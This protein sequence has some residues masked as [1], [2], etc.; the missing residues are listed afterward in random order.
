[1]GASVIN[2]YFRVVMPANRLRVNHYD[3]LAHRVKLHVRRCHFLIH[4]VH[5]MPIRNY[6]GIK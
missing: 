4:P 2:V 1:M 5:T 3:F 6:A